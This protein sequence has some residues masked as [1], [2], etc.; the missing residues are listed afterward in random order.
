MEWR[1]ER[2]RL[3]CPPL[4]QGHVHLCQTLFRGMA[5]SRRLLSWLTE[6]IWPLEASHTPDSMAVSVILGLRELFSSGCC[7]LLDMGSVEHSSVTARLLRESGARA[8]LGNALMDRGPSFLAKPLS[9]LQEESARVRKMCGDRLGY[10]FTPRFVLSCS[11]ELWGWLAGEDASIHRS[12][13]SSEAAGEMDDPAIR[14]A[15]GNVHLLRELG[16]LGGRTVLAHCVHLMPG[17]IE[18]L[19]CTGTAVAHCPWANL[20]LGSGIADVPEMLGSGITV[21][22]GSDGGACNNGLAASSDLRL[23]MG[24]ASLKAGPEKVTGKKWF[25]MA[26]RESAEFFGFAMEDDSV[27]LMISQQETDELCSC[28]DPWRYIVELPWRDRVKKLTCGGLV[29]YE[30]GV[31][32]TLPPLP[33]STGEA[34]S[35][36]LEGMNRLA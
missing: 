19:A 1:I 26:S 3:V 2:G 18:A 4:V 6:R 24:L 16:F 8:L 13:H 22:V 9:W 28:E 14:A 7:G 12:T 25:S 15:G 33:L 5:E 27:E 32:P 11:D 31:F 23:A 34:R 35:R 29:L 17:E 10:A 30:D 21:L 20:K 36:V